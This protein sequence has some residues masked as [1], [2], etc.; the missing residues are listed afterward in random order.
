MNW[1]R[2]E[3]NWRP[4]RGKFKEQWSLLTDSQIEAIAGKRERLVGALQE[5]YGFSKDEAE[6]CLK[7]WEG[8]EQRACAFEQVLRR[9]A[10]V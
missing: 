8:S 6:R 3:A 5:S 7:A 1:D 2:V 10:L 4:L 9:T